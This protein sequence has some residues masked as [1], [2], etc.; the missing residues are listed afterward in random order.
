M[1]A[2][3][4]SPRR[5]SG[6]R[7]GPGLVSALFS[8]LVLA[9]LVATIFVSTR[10]ESLLVRCAIDHRFALRIGIGSGAAILLELVLS[11]VVL[12]RHLSRQRRSEGRGRFIWLAIGGLVHALGTV[13]AAFLVAR[14]ARMQDLVAGFGVSLPKPQS[15]LLSISSAAAVGGIAV[16]TIAALSTWPML[17]PNAR[18]RIWLV[19]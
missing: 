10:Y 7:R 12:R 6:A 2:S 5:V 13:A 18:R 14:F 19:V 11:L 16:A 9:I 4:I 3:A 1:S 15:A 17:A 8:A